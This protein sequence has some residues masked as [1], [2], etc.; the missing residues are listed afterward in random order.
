MHTL[1]L[2]TMKTVIDQIRRLGGGG[3]SFFSLRQ[4]LK[5]DFFSCFF[6][7]LWLLNQNYLVKQYFSILDRFFNSSWTENRKKIKI[8]HMACWK[9]V[10][11]NAA[12][13]KA[14]LTSETDLM[15]F[16]WILKTNSF[17]SLNW[18]FENYSINFI[19]KCTKKL[20]F[21]LSNNKKSTKEA[22]NDV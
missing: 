11:I 1:F 18:T 5:I 16:F 2:N 10:V 20:W 7:F 4:R 6:S 9:F 13:K 17:I 8:T 21:W 12:V 14:D 15:I 3:R 22:L 19:A